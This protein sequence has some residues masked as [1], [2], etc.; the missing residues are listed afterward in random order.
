MA[1]GDDKQSFSGAGYLYKDRKRA[2]L[3]HGGLETLFLLLAARLQYNFDQW[4][5]GKIGD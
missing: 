3:V 4:Q 1:I 2:F 5:K